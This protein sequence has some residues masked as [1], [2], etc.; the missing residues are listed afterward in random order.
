MSA[1]KET[2]E[3][4]FYDM[5]MIMKEKGLGLDFVKFN[6]NSFARENMMFIIGDEKRQQLFLRN[7]RRVNNA[8]PPSKKGVVDSSIYP[9][10]EKQG[11]VEIYNISA[12]ET[13][14]FWKPNMIKETKMN[15]PLYPTWIKMPAG[16][17]ECLEV[18]FWKPD[19]VK[20]NYIY[21]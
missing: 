10:L 3:D 15:T 20:M 9:W 1:N 5:D 18:E 21:N 16:S 4:W 17:Y 7:K 2:Y 12:D 8:K 11:F 14:E 13:T 19:V 6:T